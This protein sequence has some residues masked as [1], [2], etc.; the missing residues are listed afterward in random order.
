MIRLAEPQAAPP[1][2]SN[3]EPVPL[4]GQFAIA[5]VV[6]AALERVAGKQLDP[7]GLAQNTKHDLQIQLSGTVDGQPFKQTV[8]TIL[9]IGQEQTR[10]SSVTPQLPELLTYI[11]GKLNTATRTKI[12]TET[13]AVFRENDNQLPE[14]P[15][16]DLEEVKAMLKALRQTKI[17]KARGPIRCEYC[18]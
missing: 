10:D 1:S 12:L 2:N 8:K 4:N 11:L 3:A 9:S 5:N 17:V 6:W 13:P 16:V 15:A 7:D 14:V 18:L